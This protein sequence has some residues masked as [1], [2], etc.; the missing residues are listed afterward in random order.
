M[1]QDRGSNDSNK[2]TIVNLVEVVRH[3]QRIVLPEGLT[4]E[5]A[6]EVLQRKQ[7]QEEEAIT[8]SEPIHVFPWDGAIA[9]KKAMEQTY[10]VAFQES[11]WFGA[12]QIG[13][14]I[15]FGQ[16]VQVPWGS[17]TVPG[18]EGK[19]S[20]GVDL[21]DGRLIFVVAAEVKRKYEE[22]IKELI[23][24]TRKLA[25][26][27]SIYRGKAFQIKFKK[28]NDIDRNA[29][30]RFMDLHGVETAIFSEDLQGE[31]DTNIL[32][33]I[34]YPDAV[35]AEGTPLKRGVLLAGGYGVGKT[36]LAHNIAVQATQSGWTFLYC[37]DPRE[38]PDA[39]QFMQAYQPG[40]VFV[41]DI[42]QATSGERS[43]SMN[44][45]L[46]HL[47]GIATKSA[48]IITIMTT[49]DVTSINK[50]MLRPGR[51]DVLLFIDP[52]NPNAV[53]RLIRTYAN[54][55]VPAT[56][57]LAEVGKLLQGRIPAV[58][59]E[60]VERSKLENLRRTEGQGG[61]LTAS[62]LVATAKSYIRKEER[63]T[64]MD[65]ALADQDAAARNFGA[66]LGE[67]IAKAMA[68]YLQRVHGEALVPPPVKPDGHDREA[69]ALLKQ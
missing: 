39:L 66:G 22:K 26:D 25:A 43:E 8:M 42:D 5:A 31:I 65:P 10:G 58:I 33:P 56:E 32:V 6:I 17:F 51:I 36:L 4:A 24:L 2:T 34:L 49:N 67:P 63:L 3:G 60:V 40:L 1:R 21:A 12:R 9:L 15:G 38:L 54:G 37:K 11:G 16:T 59:R 35:R 7:R 29:Q 45:I 14:E 13:V 69:A 18:I 19:I 27:E 68:E 52:P 41:E 64:S 20:C 53:G 61:P 30:P 44:E 46:N 50:A 57:D 47:D 28:G 48:E 62:D 23:S 55:R